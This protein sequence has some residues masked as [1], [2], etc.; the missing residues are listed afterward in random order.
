M[1]GGALR[2]FLARVKHGKAK[3]PMSG[4]G[5]TVSM[6]ATASLSNSACRAITSAASWRKSSALMVPNV[7]L[8]SKHAFCQV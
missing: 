8:V 4:F 1:S 3:S 5:G 6:R 7:P 2:S